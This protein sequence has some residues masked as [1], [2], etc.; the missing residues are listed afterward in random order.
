VAVLRLSAWRT[1]VVGFVDDGSGL[2]SLMTGSCRET[3]KR[4]PASLE[5][6]ISVMR[7]LVT[8]DGLIC[9]VDALPIYVL[10][11]WFVELF[12]IHHY[13]SSINFIIKNIP[14]SSSIQK[15]TLVELVE[16]FI[17]SQARHTFFR[18]QNTTIR[19]DDDQ[20]IVF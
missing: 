7:W 11:L 19:S 18:A 2:L 1:P 9:S 3:L 14:S 13:P 4:R 6:T 16:R 5:D 17:F 8:D 20:L 12:W 15:D 10:M